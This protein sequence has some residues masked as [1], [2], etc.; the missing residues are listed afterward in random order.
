MAGLSAARLIRDFLDMMAAER[1]ASANTIAAYRRDLES[2]DD[3][4]ADA[5]KTP[6]DATTDTI[7]GFLASLAAEGMK[8]S[9]AARKLSA[10]RQFHAFLYGENRRND[11][12]SVII[13]GPKRGR[14]L[15]KIM[16]T[17]EVDRL[18]AVAREGIDDETR[19][20]IHARLRDEAKR[21]RI[22][23]H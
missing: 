5:G 21:G 8:S 11:D 15:P 13:E 18:L 19:R 10:V 3:H 23:T 20:A 14:S 17:G 6:L 1:G 7:R 12:P 16:T 9:S 2:Y 4:L 22:G